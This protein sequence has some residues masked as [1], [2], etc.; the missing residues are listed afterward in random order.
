MSNCSPV[1]L[2][3]SQDLRSRS[4]EQS[5]QPSMAGYSHLN[6]PFS[7]VPGG[8]N[9]GPLPGVPRGCMPTRRPRGASSKM[10]AANSR[11]CWLLSQPKFGVKETML[12]TD[13]TTAQTRSTSVMSMVWVQIEREGE[14][15]V[16]DGDKSS[17]E[18]GHQRMLVLY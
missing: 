4:C 6:P 5:S 13:V 3:R 10:L 7:G 1:A 12:M 16:N 2:L 11:G 17:E 9:L 18:E 14:V 8:W 15:L